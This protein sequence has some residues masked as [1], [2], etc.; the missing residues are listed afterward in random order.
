[1]AQSTSGGFLRIQFNQY[2][3]QAP[4]QATRIYKDKI[5]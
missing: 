3:H 2:L 1:M 5:V 4:F